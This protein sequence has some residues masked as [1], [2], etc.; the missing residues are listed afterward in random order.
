MPD[1]Q[2]TSLILPNATAPFQ[3]G[4]TTPPQASQGGS[5]ISDP[6]PDFNA[7]RSDWVVMFDA[8]EGQRHIKAK[9][10]EYLPAT[11]GMRALSNKPSKLDGE[12]LALYVAYLT[13]AFFPDLVK[14]TIR[15]LVGILD[16][17]PS[18]IELPDALEDMRELATPK[19]E[20]LNDLLIQIHI[21]QLLYGRLGL[22]LDVDPNRDLPLLVQ[23]PAPQVLNWDDLTVTRSI[24]QQDDQKRSE[25]V[26]RLLMVVLD[27][28][29]FERDTG[30]T[31]TWNLVPR[32]RVLNLGQ[33]AQNVYTSQVERDGNLQN[34]IT[35]AIRGKTMDEI[36][37]VFI[38]TTDLATKPG[39]VPLINLAN[40]GLA[41]Y[42][43]EADHRSALF[44]SG[45]DT[46]VITGYDISSGS[47]ENPDD[48]ASPIID[49]GAYLNIPDPDGDAK[50]IGPDSK[51]LQEQR[52][53]LA[54][55][56]TRAGE[57][58][59]KL[60]SSGAGAEAAETVRIRV[61]GRT[62][63]L[64]TIAMTSATGLETAL[65]I[66]A[67][68][69]GADPQEVKVEPNLDFITEDKDP[70]DLI[71]FATAKKSKLPLSWKSVHNWL[72]TKDFT[73]LTFEEEL[74]QIEEEADM[75][76]FDTGG[77]A[78]LG[79]PGGGPDLNDPRMVAQ[80]QAAIDAAQ[81]GGGPPEGDQTPPGEEEG[82]GER[83][84]TGQQ[85]RRG[86]F[87]AGRRRPGD[88]GAGEE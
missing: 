59:I 55:D 58:G 63:T 87:V 37:F 78:F 80:R 39:E 81:G 44:M 47:S 8:N 75:D 69:V 24:K 61:A 31:F 74:E 2:T 35:P 48:N 5:N 10:T 21:N 18:N 25:A 6:H 84:G 28:T 9:T 19:G 64:Q 13:R 36:P 77:D 3:P 27:E 76:V 1:Q 46:L 16:R 29:R 40:L 15:A 70:A 54:D 11:S 42:R 60:L 34:T 30:N 38:N 65:R 83:E 20:S 17:E 45:Q 73:E 62:A 53:S 68:W 66:A 71:A 56:Y 12:G 43:G 86:R 52:A 22:L 57:E 33:A 4:I 50:F 82:G 49:S 72:R 23:Y 51:A 26:R 41:I 7:R 14:E 85:R 79:E 88:Q 32:F 67:V